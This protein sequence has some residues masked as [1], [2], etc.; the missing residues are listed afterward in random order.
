MDGK[1]VVAIVGIVALVAI[2]TGTVITKV[3]HHRELA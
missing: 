2:A 3:R 1:K